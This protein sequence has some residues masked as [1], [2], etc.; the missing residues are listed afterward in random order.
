M[1]YLP[2]SDTLTSVFLSGKFIYASATQ[3]E[4][5][6]LTFFGGKS[7]AQ[8]YPGQRFAIGGIGDG[9]FDAPAFNLVRLVDINTELDA[10]LLTQ[11]LRDSFDLVPGNMEDVVLLVTQQHSVRANYRRSRLQATMTAA[12]YAPS[13]LQHVT[14]N[15][16][17]DAMSG[18]ADA[19]AVAIRLAELLD[20]AQA[21]RTVVLILN[22]GPSPAAQRALAISLSQ[23]L[24]A[25]VNE[26]RLMVW[27]LGFTPRS[28][29]TTLPV[30]LH[31]GLTPVFNIPTED[32]TALGWPRARLPLTLAASPPDLALLDAAKWV[33]Q[34]RPGVFPPT[35]VSGTTA[36]TATGTNTV[37]APTLQHTTTIGPR[38]VVDPEHVIDGL[39]DNGAWSHQDVLFASADAR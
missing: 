3:T 39:A 38:M 9:R 15:Y 30:P 22:L 20:P 36:T 8:R 1:I 33:S 31:R 2:N 18:H 10:G 32:L 26:P 6:S 17:G 24:Q 25:Y 23:Q 7:L 13:Q 37:V 34:C 4:P 16:E 27:A 11:N 21:Q 12:H 19:S 35:L 5:Y 29:T 14:I 28:P